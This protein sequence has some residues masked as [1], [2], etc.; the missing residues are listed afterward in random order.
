M[1][2][3]VPTA[4]S[5]SIWTRSF[6]TVVTAQ[7][8]FGYASSTFLLLPK[9]LAM[10]AHAS[11]SQIG[12]V[13]AVTGVAAVAA[14][15]LV[16]AA[17]DRFGRKPLILLGCAMTALYAFGWV[18]VTGLGLRVDALQVL[19]GV[20]FMFAFNAAGT[21][22]ADQAPPARL[23]Q[24]IGVFGASNMAMSAI[25]PA[26]AE[27]LAVRV[28]WR[29][30]FGLA[31]AV[32]LVALALAQRIDERGRPLAQPSRA[33]G[34]DLFGVQ[35]V[36]AL[37]RRQLP[38]ALAMVSCGAAFA[39]VSTFYQPFVLAQG[40][41]HVSPFFVGFTVASVATRV[42]FGS[43]PDRL[44]RRRTAIASYIG[45]ALMV[46]LMT[47]LTPARLLVFGFMFGCA[48]GVFYPAL[49][50]MCVEQAPAAERGRAMTLVMGSFR[51]GNVVSVLALGWVAELYGYRAVF[52]LAALGS[53]LGVAALFASPD[54]A[55]DP[56]VDAAG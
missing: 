11:A 15:P 21:L 54:D 18:G 51:L 37:L 5:P 48:H 38:Q 6:L 22:V 2:D 39:A 20:G 3:A 32:A 24:A 7:M 49:S 25:A 23:G 8:A 52:V 27:L 46:L 36:L 53:A 26:A 42:F 55:S 13:M 30:A 19:G 35:A 31:G 44:G 34:G 10:Q 45:Y 29:A 1:F 56:C 47:L 41:T 16:G 40:A 17:I 12:H 28:G 9:Y 14:I 43:L 4:E 50:A 33:T